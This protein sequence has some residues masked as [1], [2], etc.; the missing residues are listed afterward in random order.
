MFYYTVDGVSRGYN[1]YYGETDYDETDITNY[2][3]DTMGANITFGYPISETA[4][5]METF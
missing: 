2:N 3:V 1:L 4:S 5:L